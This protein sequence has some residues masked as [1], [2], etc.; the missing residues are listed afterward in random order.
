MEEKTGAKTGSEETRMDEK[1]CIKPNFFEICDDQSYFERELNT[2]N[3]VICPSCGFIKL[4]SVDHGSKFHDLHCECGMAAT[5][6]T[7]SEEEIAKMMDDRYVDMMTALHDKEKRNAFIIGR[8]LG[9]S[10][11]GHRNHAEAMMRMNPEIF[12]NVISTMDG[13]DVESDYKFRD[14]IVQFAIDE[15]G[16]DH[17][18]LGYN[19]SLYSEDP[20]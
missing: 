10:E 15:L 1:T 4:S 19:S 5:W 12:K 20:K 3:Y 17:T 9:N 7:F 18:V 6:A 8:V 2:R 11:M 14:L 13:G 16:I